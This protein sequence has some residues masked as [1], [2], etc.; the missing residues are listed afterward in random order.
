MRVAVVG[1]GLIGGSVGLALRRARPRGRRLR[2][3][4]ATGSRARRSSA[5]ST[6]IA[7]RRSTTR[8]RGADVVSSRCRS[9][10]S[11]TRSS[12]ALD[13]G[14]AVVTDVGS[15]KAPVVAAVEAARPDASARFVGGHPMAGSEQD[16]VDGADAD[17]FVGATWVLTPTADDRRARVHARAARS[18]ASSAPRS[19]TVTPEHHDVLVALV[20]HV[21][22]LA[23]IDAH[24][25]RDD[26]RR[27]APHAAAPRGRRLPRH[28]AHR[29]R[30]SRHLARHPRRQPR[31][32]ARRARRVP[33]RARTRARTLVAAGDRDGAARRCWSGPASARRNLPVGVVDRRP[34]SSSCASRCPTGPACSP[35][36]RRSPGGSA[37][38]SPTSR[39]RTR[40]KAA[41]GV[42]V[43]VVAAADADAFEAGL[44]E[45]GYHLAADASSRDAL[46]G[47][48]RVRRRRARCA[49]GCGCRATSRSRTARC[50]SPRSP[51]AASTITHLATGD[52]VARDARRARRSSACRSATARRRGHRAR[53]AASTGWR[54]PDDVLDCGN[55]GTTMRML[56]GVLAGRPFLSVLTGDASLR[57]AADGAR[58][59]AA[60]R[61]G[62]ARRRPRRRRRARRS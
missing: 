48:A 55:S 9:A 34:T 52:D 57:A 4:R 46:P 39:S 38:T 37:S 25:R 41:R 1:T 43:L 7:P 21:P 24:G 10:R 32:G 3:R 59:R 50:C 58:R 44:H 31:R 62:R 54:E 16:G 27:G 49:A 12:R 13:A 60:A 26:A 45:L 40:S 47:R 6:E 2:P 53:R 20:S 35:R 19:S 11:P 8:S 28:D 18:S 56:S 29:G 15:V 14:A 22:Q 30:P 33:R 23:A 51:T 61:D 36:S 5:R 42:L 17:L